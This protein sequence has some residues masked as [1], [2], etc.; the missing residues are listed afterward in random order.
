MVE[1][2]RVAIAQKM[3]APRF[4]VI[5]LLS[6]TLMLHGGVGD[7]NAIDKSSNK[8]KA[9]DMSMQHQIVPTPFTDSKLCIRM[10]ENRNQLL[11]L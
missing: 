6:F 11:I 7:E 3:R 2:A 5:K 10:E 1:E 4:H 8:L 9:G